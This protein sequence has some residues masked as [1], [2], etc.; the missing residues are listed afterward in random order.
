MEICSVRNGAMMT[1]KSGAGPYPKAKQM[2][3]N[4]G[5]PRTA[6]GMSKNT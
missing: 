1:S 6:G 5:L 2:M 3:L 4:N